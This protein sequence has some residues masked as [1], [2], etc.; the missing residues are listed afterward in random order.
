MFILSLSP[1]NV[2]APCPALSKSP[3]MCE[4]LGRSFIVKERRKEGRKEGKKGRK[5]DIHP[6]LLDLKWAGCLEG[7]KLPFYMSS[8][9][10]GGGG[11]GEVAQWLEH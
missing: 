10:K 4:A 5:G 8:I 11:A 7:K 2:Y 3:P 9:K 6:V 1:C